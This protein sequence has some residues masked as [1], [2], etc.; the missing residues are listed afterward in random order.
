M[1]RNGSGRGWS[2]LVGTLLVVLLALPPAAWGDGS[3]AHGQIRAAYDA[4]TAAIAASDVPRYMAVLD[5]D[6]V[7]HN[8]N[9]RDDSRARTEKDLTALVKS[10]E[11]PS[12][13]FEVS[14]VTVLGGQ[15][16]VK[17]VQV[18]RCE[19]PLDAGGVRHVLEARGTMVDT[20]KKTPA[21]WRLVSQR[22]VSTTLFLDGK[23]T[24]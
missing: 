23:P 19:A 14:D 8:Q 20:W 2:A 12:L 18:F 16:E 11:K 1:R 24:P 6:Y 4:M 3:T 21:G 15:A 22:E 10:A 17:Q 13:V 7:F 5:E 9:G